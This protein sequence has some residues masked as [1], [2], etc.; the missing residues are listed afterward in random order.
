MRWPESPRRWRAARSGASPLPMRRLSSIQCS[1]QLS[2][3]GKAGWLPRVDFKRS[4]ELL[5]R[6][7]H[8]PLLRVD[9]PQ[10]HVR[11]VPWLIARSRLSLLQPLDRLV[12]LPLLD[13]VGPDV[14]VRVAEG[15]VD[16]DRLL[17]LVDC[18]VQATL[19]AVGPA[20]ERVCLGGG[21]ERERLRVKLDR[22]IE[23]T[24]QMMF[25]PFHPQRQCLVLENTVI[26]GS[27]RYVTLSDQR[28]SSVP[29][30]CIAFYG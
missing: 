28:A 18:L 8:H 29:M 7:Q 6:A 5:D 20:A 11:E 16:S 13:E 26:H 10:V 14:V 17:T 21:V 9:T 19:K 27:L 22:A 1:S 3:C 2:Q 4:L 30:G 23:V 25:L 12:E 24:T 15:L